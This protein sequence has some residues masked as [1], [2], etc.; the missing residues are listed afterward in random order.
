MTPKQTQPASGTAKQKTWKLLQKTLSREKFIFVFL[1]CFPFGLIRKRN[2][3]DIHLKNFAKRKRKKNNKK[4][5]KGF[6][7]SSR[8]KLEIGML[9]LLFSAL[10]RKVLIENLFRAWVLILWN[11]FSLYFLISNEKSLK[12][13]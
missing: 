11:F 13:Q 9:S 10:E 4:E 7:P 8:L 12:C 3:T 2:R 6:L 5:A 1:F